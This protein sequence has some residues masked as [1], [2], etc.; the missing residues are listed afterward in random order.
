MLSVTF[1]YSGRMLKPKTRIRLQQ[2]PVVWLTTVRSDGQPQTSVVWFLL[3]DDEIIVYSADTTRIANIEGNP[4]VALNL[5]GDE[6]GGEV[7]TL[8]GFARFDPDAPRA[9]QHPAYVGKY[10]DFMREN[11]W[12]PDDF[13]RLYPTAIRIEL[14]RARAW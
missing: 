14:T 6:Q 9:S 7:V 10:L 11:G 13:S 3:E 2:E 5:D 4:L 8:E 12:S 1:S